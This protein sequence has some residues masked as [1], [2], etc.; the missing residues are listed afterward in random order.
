MYSEGMV[1]GDEGL[2][3]ALPDDVALQCLLRVPPQAHAHLQRVSRR[4]RDL[5]NSPQ[6]YED[7]KREGTTTQF[8]CMLQA[9]TPQTQSFE[10][11]SGNSSTKPAPVFGIS[12]LNVQ[13]RTWERLPPIPE[14][15]EGLP[16][17]CR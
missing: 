7:R 13:Q 14:L 4:W 11:G 16:L 15:P 9:V 6:Y 10:K 17:F 5:V 8:V 3:P 12:V 1:M 2:I